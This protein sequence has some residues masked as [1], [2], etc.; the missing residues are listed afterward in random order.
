MTH[1][2]MFF[3][4]RYRHC[5]VNNNGAISFGKPMSSYTPDGFPIKGANMICPYWADT[6]VEDIPPQMTH[7]PCIYWR[8]TTEESL[9][10]SVSKDLNSMFES[11]ESHVSIDV[12]YLFLA[13]W[14]R[15]PYHGSE[16]NRTNTFQCVFA[17]DKKE[18]SYVMFN[19]H[20]IN[21]TTGTA[22][23]GDAHTGLGGIPAQAGFNTEDNYFNMPMSRTEHIINIKST[24]N[25]GIPGRWVFRVDDFAVPG[26]CLHKASTFI[27]HKNE[28]K[29]F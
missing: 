29:G 17:S 27:I 6:D 13:T 4:K 5:F 19:Y 23:D 20:D 12:N 3:G 25:C 7:N 16:S 21:W 24:T 11:T 28:K 10:K 9:R 8:Q 26:G 1:S 2:F 14:H 15:V 18:R 22:S